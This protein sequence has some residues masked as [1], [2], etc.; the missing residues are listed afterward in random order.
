MVIDG[1]GRF[2]ANFP[3]KILQITGQIMAAIVY[4]TLCGGSKTVSEIGGG[5][6][7]GRGEGRARGRKKAG[8]R[9][10]LGRGERK[11]PLKVLAD[12]AHTIVFYLLDF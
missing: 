10:G 12:T 11:Y 6:E 2:F 5:K 8:G 3:E 4:Q 9:A 7:G 1:S